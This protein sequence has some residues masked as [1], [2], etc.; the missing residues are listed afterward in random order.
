V[1]DTDPRAWP[2]RDRQFLL[3]A[4]LRC[5]GYELAY[6]C[7]VSTATGLGPPYRSGLLVCI[8]L[9]GFQIELSPELNSIFTNGIGIMIEL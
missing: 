7:V 6:L 3:L 2:D 9:P 4:A 8:A 1:F 5:C